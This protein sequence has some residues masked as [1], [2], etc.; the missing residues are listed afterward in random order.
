MGGVH[1]PINTSPIKLLM[2]REFFAL[3]KLKKTLM[4]LNTENLLNLSNPQELRDFITL[5]SQ[6]RKGNVI[7]RQTIE[8]VTK[9][10]IARTEG[11]RAMRINKAQKRLHMGNKFSRALFDFFS[12]T[13]KFSARIITKIF[14]IR[15]FIQI[16]SYDYK[17]DATSI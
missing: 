17:N 14:N 5:I 3:Q 10:D 8:R 4:Q 9:F 11:F 2:Y 16:K 12:L 1:P 7:Q 6:T 13:M 15:K